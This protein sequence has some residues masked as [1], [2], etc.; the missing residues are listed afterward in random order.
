MQ[1]DNLH[2]YTNTAQKL[3]MICSL[4]DSEQTQL[5]TKLTNET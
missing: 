5:Y 3:V 1:E 2:M 4:L